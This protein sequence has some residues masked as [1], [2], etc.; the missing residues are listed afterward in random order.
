MLLNRK[1][2]SV[3]PVFNVILL[4]CFYVLFPSPLTFSFF[5]FFLVPHFLHEQQIKRW[6]HQKLHVKY[7]FQYQFWFPDTSRSR[8][9]SPVAASLEYLACHVE[10]NSLSS[11]YTALILVR[12]AQA[13]NLSQETPLS[14]H[15]SI[16][17]PKCSVGFSL[18]SFKA[19]K[20]FLNFSKYYS[21]H[22]QNEEVWG[23]SNRI[24]ENTALQTPINWICF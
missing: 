14:V 8:H 17:Q 12:T 21:N 24:S 18:T 19:V 5:H 4:V 1:K 7:A 20:I 11:V 15:L 22:P 6:L 16:R 10:P 9:R 13:K 2:V 23:L 3:P